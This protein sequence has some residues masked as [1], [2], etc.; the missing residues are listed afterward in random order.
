M[1]K[2]KYFSQN[3]REQINTHKYWDNRGINVPS[4]DEFLMN[5][6]LV[7]WIASLIGITE[8]PTIVDLGG[9]DGSML[10]AINK[11]IPGCDLTCVDFSSRAINKGKKEYNDI[12][13]ITADIV[14]YA[15]T[16]E[17]ADV[18]LINHTLEHFKNPEEFVNLM[19]TKCDYLAIGIPYKM[20]YDNPEHLCYYDENSFSE[21]DVYCKTII[22]NHSFELILNGGEENGT[23]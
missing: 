19:L 22:D 12:K 13:F 20:A 7:K 15:E 4:P 5:S 17:H 21:F 8:K 18:I 1:K 23:K 3:D 16:M 11:V 10:E 14:K 2:I 6:Q 9:S